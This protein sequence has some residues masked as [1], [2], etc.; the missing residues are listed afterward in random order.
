MNE[1]I[2]KEEYKGHTIALWPDEDTENPLTSYD[3]LGVLGHWHKRSN[4]GTVDFRL[5]YLASHVGWQEATFRFVN[6]I[7]KDGGVVLPVGLLE[8][9]SKHLYIGA[10]GH[11]QDPG[12][13]DS[14][15]VG[16]IWAEADQIRSWFQV[17][18]I[19]KAIRAKA[20]EAL[21]QQVQTY[22]DYLNGRIVHFTIKDA[23]GNVVGDCG[24]YYPT[25]GKYDYVIAEAKEEIEG[26]AK[27]S[28]EKE[29]GKPV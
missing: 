29:K 9:G 23:K 21:R 27:E 16:F 19:T 18:K 22:D 1:P 4:V 15:Q 25:E 20:E 2:H 12:G 7:E 5:E 3:Q 26:W 13:W 17:K 8:H 28:N 10:G 14:G 24:G 11:P 6:K